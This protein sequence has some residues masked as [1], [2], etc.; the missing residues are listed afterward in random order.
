MLD[1]ADFLDDI[2][3]YKE[4]DELQKFVLSSNNF[5][6]NKKKKSFPQ[7]LN[8]KLDFV[9]NNLNEMKDM[10]E[11]NMNEGGDTKVTL[12]NQQVEFKEHD[13]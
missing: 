11:E 7:T 3:F 6:L 4:A 10:F 9:N 8:M 2:G 5:M 13:I 12:D 1:L